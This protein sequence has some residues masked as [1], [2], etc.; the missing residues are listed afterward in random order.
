[1]RWAIRVI[2]QWIEDVQDPEQTAPLA[3]TAIAAVLLV[4]ALSVV[5]VMS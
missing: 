2:H 1:M 4:A 3:I 5:G